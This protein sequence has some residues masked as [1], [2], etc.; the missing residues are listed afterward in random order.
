LDTVTII[1]TTLGPL[2]GVFVG[3]WVAHRGQARAWKREDQRYLVDTRRQTY[4]VFV[5]A[6]RAYIAYA[7]SPRASVTAIDD[8]LTGVPIPILDETGT[9][10]RERVHVANAS[11]RLVADSAVTIEHARQLSR[12]VR[13][14]VAARAEHGPGRIPDEIYRALWES[15]RQFINTARQELGMDLVDYDV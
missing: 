14:A 4:S 6:V 12:A 5:S 8:P 1:V 2:L 9:S 11:V 10:Y 3:G 13:R 15:E 7:Q